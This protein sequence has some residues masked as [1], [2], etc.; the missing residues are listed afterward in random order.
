MRI[1]EVFSLHT[2]GS[3]EP[4]KTSAELNLFVRKIRKEWPIFNK[5]FY[6]TLKTKFLAKLK[7]FFFFLPD[8]A[9]MHSI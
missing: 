1:T 3:R 2:N 8:T 6:Y 7:D 4:C 5:K 9:V